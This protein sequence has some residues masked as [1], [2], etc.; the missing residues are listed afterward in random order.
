MAI[1]TTSVDGTYRFSGLEPDEP[2]RIVLANTTP[3]GPGALEGL[4]P[5]VPWV[6]TTF[7]GSSFVS[8]PGATARDS[9]HHLDLHGAVFVPVDPDEIGASDHSLDLGFRPVVPDRRR[10]T[11]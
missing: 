6:G 2:Y 4:E 7:D 11:D 1:T 3:S 8:L 10:S 5:T 9:G